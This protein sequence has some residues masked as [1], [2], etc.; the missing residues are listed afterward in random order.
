MSLARKPGFTKRE[1]SFSKRVI[2]KWDDDFNE[3]R[4]V[5]QCRKAYQETEYMTTGGGEYEETGGKKDLHNCAIF[6]LIRTCGRGGGGGLVRCD[7]RFG[8]CDGF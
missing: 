3:M 1:H 5:S 2:C 8:L 7:D 4:S 6:C